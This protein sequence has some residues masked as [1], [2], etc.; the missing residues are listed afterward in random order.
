MKGLGKACITMNET[1]SIIVPMYNV[2]NY[3]KETIQSVVSQ[4]YTDWELLLIDDCSSDGTVEAVKACRDALGQVGNKIR[5]IT[6]E[7]NC[8]AAGTRNRGISEASGRYIAFLDGD[9]LWKPDKLMKELTFLKEKQAAFVFTGYEFADEKGKGTGKIVKVPA[10]L[11]YKQALSNTTIFTTT[12][13]FDTEKLSKELLKMPA[14]KSEDTATW[15]KIL[16]N[17]YLAYGLDENLAL[18]RRAGKSLS[19]N[20]LEA[21]RRI[22]NLYRK[23]EGLSVGCSLYHFVLWAV[24]A[25]WRR[26]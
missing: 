20:K 6:Q 3:I 22:W 15:W 4:T 19:S 9:D 24:R 8:G 14:V 5:L 21:I 1:I 17:G 7:A 11:E 25:V 10:T 2:C 23:T 26:I 12:V 16:K 13:L 18:Y